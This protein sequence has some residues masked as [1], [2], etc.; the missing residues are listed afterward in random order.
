MSLVR[1]FA[2]GSG[3]LGSISGRVIPKNQ[4]M[5]LDATLLN[6]PYYKVRIK[7]KVEQSRETSSALPLS[8]GVVAIKKGAFG[9]P[10]TTIAN[11]TFT[12]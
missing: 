11:F 2:S 5:T 7:G 8:L 6:N 9:S 3:D 12:L 1:V 10:S 4:K